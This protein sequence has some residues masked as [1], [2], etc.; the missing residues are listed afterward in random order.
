MSRRCIITDEERI[1]AV[2]EYLNGEGSY[3]SIAKKYSSLNG[4]RLIGPYRNPLKLRPHL[5]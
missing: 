4:L 2:Q 3:R 1:A 5:R